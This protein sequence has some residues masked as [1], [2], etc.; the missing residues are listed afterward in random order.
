MNW[1]V[2]SAFNTCWQWRTGVF[3]QDEV[4]LHTE[5]GGR[6]RRG[7]RKQG[8]TPAVPHFPFLTFCVFFSLEKKESSLKRGNEDEFQRNRKCPTVSGWAQQLWMW[9]HKCCKTCSGNI[10]SSDMSFCWILHREFLALVNG[11]LK[12]S[13]VIKPHFRLFTAFNC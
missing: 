8:E 6:R 13:N 2:R 9:D 10:S 1:T 4:H 11:M 7:T 12:S 3:D 5:S